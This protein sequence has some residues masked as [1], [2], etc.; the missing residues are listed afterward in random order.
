MRVAESIN[1]QIVAL[2]YH[3]DA[4]HACDRARLDIVS[5]AAQHQ[6]NIAQI[7]DRQGDCDSAHCVSGSPF[8]SRSVP[9]VMPI[10]YCGCMYWPGM[11]R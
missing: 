11:V 2:G 5:Q 9:P 7:A 1:V 6:R 8:A 4:M 10:G 3:D